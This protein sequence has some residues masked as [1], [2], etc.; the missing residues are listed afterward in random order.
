MASTSS[1]GA[2]S[3]TDCGSRVITSPI[4]VAYGSLPAA[5][6]PDITLKTDVDGVVLNVANESDAREELDVN[7]L[8]ATPTEVVGLD[9]RVV[10]GPGHVWHPQRPYS[11][12]AIHPYPDQLIRP[13]V[14][15]DGATGARA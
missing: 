3:E 14:D 5:S 10:V 1:M 4:C 7:P 8:V 12:L 6:T 13:G 11:H 15:D 2:F 9:A